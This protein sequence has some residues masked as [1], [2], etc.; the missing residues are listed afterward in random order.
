VLA[1]D[2]KAEAQRAADHDL[3]PTSQERAAGGQILHQITE[4]TML[5]V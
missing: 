5:V 4:R 3:G 1:G 2:V